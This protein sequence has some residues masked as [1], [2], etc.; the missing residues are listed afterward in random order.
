ME[1]E[2]GDEV[3]EKVRCRCTVGLSVC[4]VRGRL[5]RRITASAWLPKV[6]F[7]VPI[8]KGTGSTLTGDSP[9]GKYF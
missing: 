3:G 7:K 8:S 1:V 2:E 6:A 5:C 4:R 9:T